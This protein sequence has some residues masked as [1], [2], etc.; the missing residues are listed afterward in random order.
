[1]KI[2]ITYASAG[3]GHMKAAEAVYTYI[4]ENYKDIDVK[5]LDVLST[6][7]AFFSASYNYGYAFLVKHMPFLWRLAFWITDVKFLRWFSRPIVSFADR[8]HT[9]KFSRLLTEENPDC[10]ISAHFMTSQIAAR[11]KRKHRI[12]SRLVTIVTDFGVHPFWVSKHTDLYVVA[13]NYTHQQL[14]RKGASSKDRV[15]E[16]GIPVSAKFSKPIDK[17]AVRVKLGIVEGRFTVLIATGSF[18]IGPIEEITDLLYNDVQIL[19]VCAKNEKLFAKLKA[20]NYPS[21]IVVFG[22]I[23]NIEELMSVSDMIITKPGGLSISE[24]LVMGL[25][26][27]FI[28]PIPGQEME[29]IKALEHYGVGVEMEDPQAIKSRVLELKEHP[30]RLNSIRDKINK[31]K[32]PS[33]A[34]E[35]CDAVCKGSIWASS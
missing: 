30:E 18:G 4:K 13:S 22:F 8:L 27:I 32:K 28:S 16:W 9:R 20:K 7:D 26:P 1:M 15:R 24:S 5:L 10:I 21:N 6:T 31:I 3:A 12:T 11:L 35:L 14:L 29:N 33:A 2:I 17:A 25:T 34:R 19:I 23:N